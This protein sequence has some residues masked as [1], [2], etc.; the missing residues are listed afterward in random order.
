L[1]ASQSK[2]S[3]IEKLAPVGAM[4]AKNFAPT[5]QTRAPFL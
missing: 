3:Q 5:A 4:R 1:A 2:D